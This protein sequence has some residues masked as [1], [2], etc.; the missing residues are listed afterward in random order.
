MSH[1]RG[2]RHLAALATASLLLAVAACSGPGEE[3]GSSSSASVSPAGTPSTTPSAN[4]SPVVETP[5]VP[6]A[7]EP[8]E[9][10]KGRG[11]QK[12]FV[13]FVMA[14]WSW[15]LRSNDAT[16]L[17]EVSLG[18]DPCRGCTPLRK[19]LESRD[20]D[21]WYVDFPGLHVDRIR[22]RPA[23]RD[24]VARA[25]VDI[26]QSDTLHEDGSYR[27]TNPAHDDATFSVRIRLVKGDYRLV[28][29][30]VS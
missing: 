25:R 28:S 27:S 8:P 7:P 19:E 12:Q 16:P 17:L 26:P 30:G 1:G 6:D 24:T 9:T 11:G 2:R 14:A 4:A 13:E 15:S 29:F 23:G 21:G 10:S 3:P 22:L 18:K 5:A 20:A